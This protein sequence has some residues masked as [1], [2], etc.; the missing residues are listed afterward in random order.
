METLS[1]RSDRPG[2]KSGVRPEKLPLAVI[3]GGFS[4]TMAAIH[5]ARALPGDQPVLLFERGVFW[6]CVAVPDIRQQ[7]EH[8][9]RVVAK[10][11]ESA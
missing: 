6:E 8:I 10:T 9:G 3:G 11:E 1:P 5:L 7:A 2:A 4:G